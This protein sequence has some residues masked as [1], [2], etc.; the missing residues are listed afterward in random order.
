MSTD[1]TFTNYFVTSYGGAFKLRYKPGWNLINLRT[2]DL[3]SG[4]HTQLGQHRAFRIRL[5]SRSVNT[6]SFDA[7][8]SGVVAQPA[9]IFTFDKGL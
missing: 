9:V 4:R 5:D 1:T 8:T 7:L 3:D 2:S 6:Y